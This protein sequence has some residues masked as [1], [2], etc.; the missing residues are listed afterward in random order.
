MKIIILGAGAIGSLFGAK[1]SELNDVTLIARKIH[2]DKI[3]KN[4]LK[5]TG[6]EEKLYRLKA[7]TEIK[8]IDE[9]TLILLTTK[10]YDSEK[11]I[12]SIKNLIR[13]DT[14]ILCLQNGLYSENIVK[15]IAGNKCPVLRAVTN[16]GA[17][18]LK[19]GAVK[20]TQ[21]SYT[22]VEKSAKSKEIADNF[23][24]CCLN[25]YVSENIKRDMWKKLAF[26]CVINP[27]TAIL[28]T[29]NREICDER[30]NPF[31]KMI[32]DECLKVAEKDG[33]KFNIDF[34]KSLNGEFRN[35]ANISSMQQDLIKG[36][37][38]EIDCL[39][40]AVAELGKKLGVNCPVNDALAAIIR[41]LGGAQTENI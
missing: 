30:L 11:A 27:V 39:N 2:A 18:F 20:Y 36:R 6:L 15:E 14:I 3:S 4:G 29:E 37:K 24:K 25:G 1:L 21:Y 12:K 9:H 22:S 32:I 17:I 5:I 41:E 26:N 33:I 7:A 16:F 31:K 13:K 8:R 28:R 19:P 40:G 23:A 35:S 38:T 34:L 10:V